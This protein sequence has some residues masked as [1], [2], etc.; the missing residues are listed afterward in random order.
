MVEKTQRRRQ[1]PIFDSMGSSETV[2]GD[3]LDGLAKVALG[4]R[5]PVQSQAARFRAALWRMTSAT[6]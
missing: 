1:Y 3:K 4:Q 2:L 5:R 6:T